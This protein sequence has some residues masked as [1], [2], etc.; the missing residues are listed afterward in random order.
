MSV[1]VTSTLRPEQTR[2]RKASA[3]NPFSLPSFET[4]EGKTVQ[5]LRGQQVWLSA[6]A[7]LLKG[8]AETGGRSHQQSRA[9]AHL[10]H[11]AWYSGPWWEGM[12]LNHFRIGFILGR[13]LSLSWML[14]RRET[15][16]SW[17]YFICSNKHL[18]YTKQNETKPPSKQFTKQVKC[19]KLLIYKSIYCSHS[20]FIHDVQVKYSLKE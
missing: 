10:T 14:Q 15:K 17:C 6:S 9:C 5:G 4:S 2:R 3:V 19:L 1:R 20:Y 8:R 12:H 18:I 7:V 13:A 16:L 11:W